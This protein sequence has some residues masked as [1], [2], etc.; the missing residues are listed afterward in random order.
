MVVEI[1]E[2]WVCELK[3]EVSGGIIRPKVK[4]KGRQGNQ[5]KAGT[6]AVTMDGRRGPLTLTV[7]VTTPNS[8]PKLPRYFPSRLPSRATAISNALKAAVSEQSHCA[9]SQWGSYYPHESRVH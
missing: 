7:A 9:E 1:I 3:V 4:G 5:K 2:D 8:A 6:S